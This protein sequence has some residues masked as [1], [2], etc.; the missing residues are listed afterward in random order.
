[1]KPKPD[2]EVFTD[3]E[4]AG[5]TD[6]DPFVHPEEQANINPNHAMILQAHEATK[7]KPVGSVVLWKMPEDF[8]PNRA[9]Q[10][11]NEVGL[12]YEV[13][14]GGISLDTTLSMS[15]RPD[16]APAPG[17]IVKLTKMA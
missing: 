17:W 15:G 12:P 2:M 1:L 14:E 5:V 11:I 16:N 6:F 13:I 3:P 4:S 8:N 9:Q 10:Y 7:E